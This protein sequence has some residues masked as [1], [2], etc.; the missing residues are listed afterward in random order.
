MQKD[1]EKIIIKTSIIGIMANIFLVGFKTFVGLAT[2]SIAI[3]LDAVNNLSDVLSSLIT[4]IGTKLAAKAPDKEHPYGHGRI[5]YL[6]AML[7]SIIILYAGATA[8]IESIKKIFNPE[9]PDYTVTSIIII[10]VAVGVKIVLGLYVKNKGKL[11]HS[12]SLENS[13]TDALM[14]SIISASTLLAAIIYITSGL[15]LE[16]YLG[17]IISV[18]II[19]SGTQMIK[20]TISQI[21]GERV[22]SQI[23]TSVK[24]TVSSFEDV[25]GA[26][27]LI[28]NNYGPDIYMGSI[29]I[30]VDDT[31]PAYKIDEL[32]RI[33]TQEVYK[34]HRVILTAVGIYSL[35]CKDDEVIQIRNNISNI[36]QTYKSIL[37]MH[38]FYLN[39]AN[40]T[41]T[42]DIIIDYGEKNR[43]KL[44]E[45]IYNKISKMYPEYKLK[46]IEDF[47]VSE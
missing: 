3:I 18:I 47:D 21:L 15:S 20:S 22:E 4:I 46:I 26:Y 35:N 19:R 28:L 12:E 17:A 33:I 29:H 37:Q 27:D 5:E 7:I 14:H 30:E 43:Q 32:T 42:F 10:I 8:L 2:N 13:G 45:E 25:H 1:R 24:E 16:A 38:G 31:M 41:I 11:V 44:Y 36:I 39:K 23:A 40:K 34:K 6:G 9:I